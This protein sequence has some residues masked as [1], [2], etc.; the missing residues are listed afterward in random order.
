MRCNN[1][2]LEH[3]FFHYVYDSSEKPSI[4]FPTCKDCFRVLKKSPKVESDF[5]CSDEL[6]L[7]KIDKLER[8]V[9]KLE[10]LSHDFDIY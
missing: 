1:C 6:A 9:R 5:L 2:K 7:F 4:P 3:N 10:R 8:R